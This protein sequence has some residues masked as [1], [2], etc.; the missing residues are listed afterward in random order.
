MNPSGSLCSRPSQL[1]SLIVVICYAAS[2]YGGISTV[3]I[4]ELALAIFFFVIFMTELDKQFQLV[5]WVWSVSPSSA[6]L[7][8]THARLCVF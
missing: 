1:L 8:H 7:S 2:F 6:P 3:A 5:N 4:V